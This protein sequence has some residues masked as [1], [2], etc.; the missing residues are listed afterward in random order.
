M[1][2]HSDVY[3]AQHPQ[4]LGLKRRA[5]RDTTQKTLSSLTDIPEPLSSQT[6]PFC[7][8]RPH[9]NTSDTLTPSQN[10]KAEQKHDCKNSH[11]FVANERTCFKEC[12]PINSSLWLNISVYSFAKGGSQTCHFSVSHI[13]SICAVLS[14][15]LGFG[16]FKKCEVAQTQMELKGMIYCS[17]SFLPS[18]FYFKWLH[19]VCWCFPV[20]KRRWIKEIN[21]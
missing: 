16:K 5:C 3:H 14:A 10:V 17:L 12:L 7:T 2:T 15:V 11:S 4:P 9:L 20:L 18:H 21:K 8:L 13:T 6:P 1:Y 19:F